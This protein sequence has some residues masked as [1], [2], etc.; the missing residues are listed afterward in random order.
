[1][2]DTLSKFSRYRVRAE[3]FAPTLKISHPRQTHQKTAKEHSDQI[4]IGVFFMPEAGHINAKGDFAYAG[5]HKSTDTEPDCFF[6]SPIDKF[7]QFFHQLLPYTS[8]YKSYRLY[9]FAPFWLLLL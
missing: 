7:A 4:S 9:Y 3:N 1:L 6:L 8:V 5:F 2:K